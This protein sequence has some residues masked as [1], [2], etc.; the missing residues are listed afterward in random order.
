MV[1]RSLLLGYSL[2]LALRSILARAWYWCMAK[3]LDGS[4]LFEV[5]VSRSR[6]LTGFL[7]CGRF[8]LDRFGAR[9]LY[10]PKFRKTLQL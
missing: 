8:L 3:I 5:R 6:E 1:R 9:I 10:R 7:G 2:F 4:H